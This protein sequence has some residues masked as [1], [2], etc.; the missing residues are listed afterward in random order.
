MENKEKLQQ[1]QYANPGNFNA[2]IYMNRMFS[3]NKYPWPCWI[4]DQ[5]KLKEPAKVLELGGGNGLLWMANAQRIPT[6]WDI[7]VTDISSGMLEDARAK[8]D[9]FRGRLHFVVM[10]AE[11]LHYP[12]GV[13]DIVIANHMLYHVDRKKTLSEIKR[14]L[15][16]DG[17]FYA[18]TVGNRNML[19]MREIVNAFDPN[20][21]YNEVLGSIES[22]FSLEN[23]RDQL[24]EHFSDVELHL[25]E[26][27]LVV[28]ESDA[29]VNYVLSM[30]GFSPDQVVLD[31]GMANR[32]KQFI[33]QKMAQS[34]GKIRIQKSSGIFISSNR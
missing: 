19:E 11:Q 8:L 31:P 20:S 2:R 13:F 30:N 34:Y 23:G 6:H 28:T 10:D 21:K 24:L 9:D 16:T 4:F 17:T 18:S 27:S 7:T 1:K 15:K 14:V 26:D 32:F 3:T 29:I 5:L 12:D 33:D 22:R 25:Y